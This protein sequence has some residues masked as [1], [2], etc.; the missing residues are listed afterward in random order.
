[1]TGVKTP[2]TADCSP[3]SALC[4]LMTLRDNCIVTLSCWTL[5]PCNVVGGCK[6]AASN[7]SCQPNYTVSHRLPYTTYTTI[8]YIRYHTLQYTIIHY[9]PYIRYHTLHTL[10]YTT[11][12][13]NTLQYTIIHYNTIHYIHYNT[14]QYTTLSYTTFTT[15]HYIRYHTLQYTTIHSV[16]HCV[17]L[18]C[19]CSRL[20]SRCC[21][22]E[23]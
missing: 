22:C 7:I 5:T 6:R 11:L 20:R 14:L 15:I 1:M 16:A 9:I 19:S 17:V 2:G 21:A 10:P 3:Y 4:T 18:M 23:D 13:Y 12:H 8:Q